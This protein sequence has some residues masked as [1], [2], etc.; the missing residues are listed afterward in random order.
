[1][2]LLIGLTDDLK[3]LLSGSTSRAALRLRECEDETCLWRA[4]CDSALLHTRVQEI[5]KDRI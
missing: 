3:V 5:L 2:S 1:M 4:R